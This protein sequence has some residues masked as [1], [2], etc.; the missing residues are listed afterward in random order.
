M[1]VFQLFDWE[2]SLQAIQQLEVLLKCSVCNEIATDPQ[3]LGRCDHFFCAECTGS[4]ENGTC[5]VCKIPAPPCEMKPDRIISGLAASTKDLRKLLKG[6]HIDGT[7]AGLEAPSRALCTPERQ[8]RPS[9]LL[10]NISTKSSLNC[11]SKFQPVNKSDINTSHRDNSKIEVKKISPNQGKIKNNMSN[12]KAGKKVK[13]ASK[14]IGGKKSSGRKSPTNSSVTNFKPNKSCPSFPVTPDNKLLKLFDSSVLGKSPGTPIINKRNSKGETPLHVACIK[15]DSE[16]VLQ[17]LKEGANPNTKD[18]A[19]WTP[20]HEA[21]SHGFQ[22]IAELLLKHG[23]IVDVPG[24]SNENP[25]HD[26]VTQGQV[27]VIKLLRTWGASDTAR[28]LFGFTP[29]SLANLCVGVVELNSAL[30]T[31]EDTTLQRPQVMTR[32]LDKI[33]L[34]GSGLSAENLRKLDNLAK[35]L[36]ARV[37]S[38]FSMD[39]THIIAHC[40]QERI[41]S[42]R[43]LKYMMGVVSGK[44]ILSHT[45]MD[46]CLSQEQAVNPQPYEVIGSS[47][48]STSSAP[49]K[50]RSHVEKM[51]PGLFNGCHMF[52]WGNFCEPYPNK[53]GLEAII[54]AGGGTVLVREPNPESISEKEQTVPFYSDENS[55]LNSCSHYIIYQDGV[56]EPQLKYDMAHIKSLP[57]SWLFSCID[58]FELVP[59]FK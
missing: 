16:K 13:S 41:V 45:W 12:S 6:G 31:P 48:N 32:L 53:K 9:N 54:K 36:R 38:E 5:P 25:L 7:E 57:L 34:L 23:A 24:G 10:Q 39:V 27:E 20:L 30:D 15:G 51:H 14:Q 3:C 11:S 29:R 18:N 58:N 4:L 2:H 33:V 44:W 56:V 26:A 19:G 46:D 1:D 40:T 55:V 28:N 52:L 22:N 43:T 49:A 21:C 50:A 17:L 37:T 35:L 8:I 42:Q 59:P 47:H